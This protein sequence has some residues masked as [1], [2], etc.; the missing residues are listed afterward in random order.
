[1]LST[2]ETCKEYKNILLGYL[3]IVFTDHKNNTFNGLKASDRVLRWLLPLEEYGVTFEYLPGK[4]NVVADAL[5]CLDIDELIIQTEEALTFLLESEH[6]S[7]KF[8]MH[9]TLIF[10]EQVRVQRLSEKGLSQPFYSMQHIEG[11]DLLC[12]KDKIY[13][14]QSLRQRVL[15]WYHEY[16]LHPGQ[17]RT[18]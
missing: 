11:Y 13:I 1:L 18:E 3:I 8:P 4:K 12:Y 7:I 5:S 2:I 15:S 6:S 14:P 9:T 10:K 17:T 16:L